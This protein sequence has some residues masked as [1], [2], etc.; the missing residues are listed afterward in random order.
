MNHD[1]KIKGLLTSPASITIGELLPNCIEDGVIRSD[2]LSHDQW[3]RVLKGLTDALAARHF[4]GANVAS[5]VPQD[6]DIAGK[7]RPMRTA[8]IEQHAVFTRHRDHL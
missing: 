8:Q 4:A 7:Q 6:D 3:P 1:A 5:I 2:C